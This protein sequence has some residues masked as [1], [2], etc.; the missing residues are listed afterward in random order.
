[1]FMATILYSTGIQLFLWQWATP[2]IMGL[3]TAALGKITVSNIPN[4][5]N[6][7]VVFVTYT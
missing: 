7:C 1:M 2:I 5:L 4:C 3:F 6:Y